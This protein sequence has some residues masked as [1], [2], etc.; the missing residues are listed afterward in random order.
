SYRNPFGV[1]KRSGQEPRLLVSHVVC[2]GPAQVISPAPSPVPLSRLSSP[3][4]DRLGKTTPAATAPDRH[5]AIPL[6]P[7]PV[8]GKTHGLLAHQLRTRTSD[9]PWVAQVPPITTWPLIYACRLNKH[10][11]IK[12]PPS[13]SPTAADAYQITNRHS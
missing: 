8:P 3:I 4:P 11:A 5:I 9:T 13:L 12:A 10:P 2:R 6:T 1:Y 7:P